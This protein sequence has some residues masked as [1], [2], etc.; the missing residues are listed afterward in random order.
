[1]FWEVFH[2][3]RRIFNHL[4]ALIA[5]IQPPQS[6]DGDLLGIDD[7]VL[8]HD[9]PSTGGGGHSTIG[10]ALTAAAQQT[11]ATAQALAQAARECMVPGQ[12]QRWPARPE[13]GGGFMTKQAPWM[14]GQYAPGTWQPREGMVPLPMTPSANNGVFTSAVTQ[15]TWTARPQKRFRGER[16]IATVLRNGASTAGVQPIST[17]IFV[18][19]DLQQAQAGNTPI[20]IWAAQAFG[21]RLYMTP[22]QPGVDITI[23]VG[24]IGAI[25]AGENITITL[26]I[27][28]RYFH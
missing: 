15:I 4:G 3:K 13:Q 6:F 9:W 12:L 22:A 11:A 24:L 8:G 19:T 2:M 17:A 18:G 10:Q 7:D 5:C 28:G 14:A 26:T 1:M 25:A 27:L 21:V 20:D 16:L 23:P